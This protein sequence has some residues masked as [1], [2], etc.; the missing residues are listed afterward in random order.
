MK[1]AILQIIYIYQTLQQVDKWEPIDISLRSLSRVAHILIGRV[2]Y[3]VPKWR[4]KGN[5]ALGGQVVSR[6]RF[7]YLSMH[8]I[9]I[10]ALLP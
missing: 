8:S 4:G 3:L 5:Y 7:F 10:V 9:L 1:A 2:P 6:K